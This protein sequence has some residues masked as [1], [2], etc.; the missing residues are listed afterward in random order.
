MGGTPYLAS[1]SKEDKD[2]SKDSKSSLATPSSVRKEKLTRKEAGE[3]KSN[4]MLLL[5][6]LLL[7]PLPPLLLLLPFLLLLL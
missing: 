2:K 7:L 4:T 1:G 6:L 3:H 5:L